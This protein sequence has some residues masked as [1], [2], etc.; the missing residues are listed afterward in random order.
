DGP[1]GSD[2]FDDS[3]T[4]EMAQR[5][6]AWNFEQRRSSLEERR[7]RLQQR[8]AVDQGREAADD[9]LQDVASDAEPTISAERPISPEPGPVT[10]AGGSRESAVDDTASEPVFSVGVFDEV[11][12]LDEPAFEADGPRELAPVL[13]PEERPA[14]AGDRTAVY[15]VTVG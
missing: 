9:A 13:P 7:R 14:F 3:L 6:A 10:R 4:E 15:A 5:A 12:A 1:H 2:G 8:L 11:G